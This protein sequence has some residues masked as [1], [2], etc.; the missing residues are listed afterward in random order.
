[1]TRYNTVSNGQRVLPVDPNGTIRA[2]LLRQ[3]AG[4]Q[5]ALE[6]DIVLLRRAAALR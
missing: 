4:V 6:S 5:A 2:D 1:M 3:V